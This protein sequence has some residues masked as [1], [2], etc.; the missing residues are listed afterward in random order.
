MTD[1]E[2]ILQE[3]RDSVWQTAYRLLGNSADAADCLQETFVSALHVSRRQRV[4]NWPALLQRLATTR[5]LDQLR[6]RARRSRQRVDMADWAEVADPAAGPARDA[7]TREQAAQLRRALADLSAQQAE[8]FC[9]RF[10]NDMSYREIA[11]EL[12]IKIN[13]V[14]VLLHRARATLRERLAFAPAEEDRE[15]S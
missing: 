3:Q 13:A 10:I 8:V 12:G 7:Q 14:G 11:R 15:V 9:L 6:R 2:T 1:W 4:R 5:A